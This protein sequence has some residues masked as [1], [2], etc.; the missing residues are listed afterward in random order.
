MSEMAHKSLLGR[1]E[2]VAN[3]E[4][5]GESRPQDRERRAFLQ[6]TVATAVAV[7]LSPWARAE[8]SASNLDPVYAEIT[9]RHDESLK[10]LQDWIHQPS[11]AAENRGVIE[12]CE[13]TMQIRFGPWNCKGRLPRIDR[14]DMCSSLVT[15]I[16]R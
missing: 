8:T 3:S 9:K 12:A 15:R 16:W 2:L 5:E 11:I 7:A 4:P 10:R 13:L 1:K 14:S 6:G